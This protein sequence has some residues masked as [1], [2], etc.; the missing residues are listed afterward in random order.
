MNKTKVFVISFVIIMIL[1][2]TII[3][4]KSYAATMTGITPITSFE[5]ENKISEG[6]SVTEE[7]LSNMKALSRNGEETASSYKT[8][9]SDGIIV[10]DGVTTDLTDMF[11]KIRSIEEQ[12]QSDSNNTNTYSKNRMGKWFSKRWCY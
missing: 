11:S 12:S 9:G 8:D 1:M 2:T 3:N 5:A 7:D 6:D 10:E 4:F